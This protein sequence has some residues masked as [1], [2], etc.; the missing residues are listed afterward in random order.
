M[1]TGI[2]DE[3]LLRLYRYKAALEGALEELALT[4]ATSVS[5][6]GRSITR[7]SS[8]EIQTQLGLTDEKIRHRLATL[9]GHDAP[10]LGAITPRPG[11]D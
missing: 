6:N 1:T 10:Y 5:I 9:A 8:A 4:R 11:V 2:Q 7:Q 3:E